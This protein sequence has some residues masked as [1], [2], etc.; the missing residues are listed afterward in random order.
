MSAFSI[1]LDRLPGAQWRSG[2]PAGLFARALPA[3]HPFVVERY[4]RPEWEMVV[5]AAGLSGME[6][7]FWLESRGAPIGPVVHCGK[8]GVLLVLVTPWPEGLPPVQGAPVR[9]GAVRCP[10]L[11]RPCSG[12]LWLMPPEGSEHLTDPRVLF[13]AFQQVRRSARRSYAP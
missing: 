11:A 13:E 1:S 2:A 10:G 5:L 8:H 4:G 3:G 6:V 7:L 12:Q 9:R